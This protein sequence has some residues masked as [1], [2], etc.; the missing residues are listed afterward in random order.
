M[1]EAS[2][3]GVSLVEAAESKQRGQEGVGSALF[4]RVSAGPLPEAAW[5]GWGPLWSGLALSCFHSCQ[6]A[7]APVSPTLAFPPG[8]QN[9]LHLKASSA[10]NSLA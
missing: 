5:V 6:W 4:P 8:P 1:P 9:L 3:T 2:G 7:A 10:P